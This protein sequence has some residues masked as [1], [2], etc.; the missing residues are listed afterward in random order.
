MGGRGS[1]SRR[2]RGATA[3]LTLFCAPFVL[4]GCA[5]NR[6][7]GVSL[8]PGA[9]DPQLQA[10]A[11][12]A[13]AGDKQAQLELGIRYE[14]GRGVPVDLGRAAHFYRLAARDTG[15]PI[16]TYVPRVGRQAGRV[17]VVNAGP[18]EPG[19]AEARARLERLQ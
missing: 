16:Y 18:R 2:R 13:R 4:A 15:G 9:A 8:I 17:V 5:T 10:L 12:R 1:S 7:A 6:Y 3:A 11:Q 19:L 14:E